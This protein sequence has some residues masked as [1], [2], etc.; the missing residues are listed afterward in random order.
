[1]WSRE[2]LVRRV[3]H[4]LWRYVTP[5]ANAEIDALE[6]AALLRMT[7]HEVHTL[8][9]R[10]FLTSD[11]LGQFVDCLP[12]LM[13]RLAT[14][15]AHEEEISTDRIRGSIQW[16]RT[17]GLRQATGVP[18]VYVTAP[19][20]RAYQTPENELLVAVLDKT[21]QLA[22]QAGWSRWTGQGVGEVVWERADAANRWQQSHMLLEVERRP[23][24][25]R[26]IGRVRSG[27]FRR[28]YQPVLDAYVRY[29]ELVGLIDR[30]AVRRA[31]ETIGIVTRD[32]PT[33]FE[34]YTTFSLLDELKDRGWK[35][36]RLGLFSGHLRLFATRGGDR[37]EVCYQTTPRG[38]SR[39]SSYRRAQ[40]EHNIAPGALR[41]D[42]VLSWAEN[43]QRRWL[44]VEVK[45]GIRTV[46]ESARAALYDLLAYRRAFDPVLSQSAKPFGLGI[47]WGAELRPSDSSD[48]VLC[49]PD[50]I[51]GAL[52]ICGL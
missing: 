8:G 28:R 27:R 38:L 22:S 21:L 16:G 7:S 48:I 26:Q 31:I 36:G 49:T 13:R 20:F 35:L 9:A 46:Q 37:L 42:L 40:I 44:L 25:P 4:D 14:T 30:R 24:T 10:Q 15:T 6:A 23:I 51:G 2:Q 17:I 5:S 45:G 29:M 33:I 41:P 18:H 43:G 47:A 34:I 32:D 3:R 1:M 52:A 19:S 12:L 50:T 11:E 39:D